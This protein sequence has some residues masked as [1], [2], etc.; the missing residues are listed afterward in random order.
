MIS[1]IVPYRD[2]APWLGRC[3]E[4]LKRQTADAEFILVNDYSLDDSDEIARMYVGSDKRFILMENEFRAGVSC[5]R[6]TGIL[7]SKG[8][9]ITFLD[10]DDEMLPGGLDTYLEVIAA[11]PDANIH[12]LNHLRY[13]PSIDKLTMKYPNEEGAYTSKELPQI[14]FGVWN[15][16]FRAAFIQEHEI[17][18]EPGVQYGEDA[19]FVLECLEEDDYINHGSKNMVAVRHNFDNR[20]SLSHSVNSDGLLRY[21]RELTVFVHRSENPSLRRATC[22][23]LSECWGS[24]RNQD[25][26]AEG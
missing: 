12:Q 20:Q 7:R 24:K 23:I 13:Y 22:K 25:I 2:A 8:E 5:A 18:F 15:K 3:I 6:N 9:W 10:A 4:S 14:W 16:I 1:V 19:L 26:I 11:D 17:L 21:M